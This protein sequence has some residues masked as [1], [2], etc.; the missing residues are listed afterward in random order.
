MTRSERRTRT[1]DAL[2]TAAAEEFESRGFA[3]TSLADVAAKLGLVR[4]TVHFHF[5]TKQDLAK[6][7]VAEFTDSWAALM[8]EARGRPGGALRGLMWVSHE[9]ADRHSTDVRLRAGLRLLGDDL[10]TGEDAP[11][12]ERTWLD[13]VAAQLKEAQTAG[14][15]RDDLDAM[16]ESWALMALF[17]GTLHMSQRIDGGR[18]VRRRVDLMWDYALSRLATKAP[19]SRRET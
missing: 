12:P 16:E 7:I 17:C 13:F 3:S 2:M 19:A 14:D 6:A 4:A 1:R 18:G 8:N 10:V 9:L 5:S 15:L 11:D